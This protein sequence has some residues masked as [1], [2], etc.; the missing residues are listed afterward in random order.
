MS[1]REPKLSGSESIDDHQSMDVV[2]DCDS[3]PGNSI[4]S[5]TEHDDIDEAIFLST[6]K[7]EPQPSSDD[8][9]C[10]DDGD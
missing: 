4:G 1:S 8:E 2:D 9:P 10:Y 3:L 7:E 6:F 5:S